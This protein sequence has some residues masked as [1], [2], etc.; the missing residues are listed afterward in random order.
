MG[1]LTDNARAL[2]LRSPRGALRAALSLYSDAGPPR[3]IQHYPERSV[4]VLA[5][6]MDDEVL[7]CGGV[8]ALHHRHGARVQVAYMTDGSRGAA[9]LAA[10]PA[11]QRA[12]RRAA[13][14]ATRR[15]E[16][17]ASGR[18]LG[19]GHQEFFDADDG[20]LSVTPALTARLAELLCGFLEQ[21]GPHLLYLPFISDGHPDHHQTAR[22]CAAALQRLEGLKVAG[23]TLRAYEVWTPLVANRVADISAVQALKQQ[24]LAC[25]R[26]QLADIDYARCVVGLNAYRALTLRGVGYAEAFRESGVANFRALLAQHGQH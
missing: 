14:R 16:A 21:P 23:L 11:P 2:L 22:L 13:L 5:P 10:L 1:A 8:L 4:L 9:G 3:P 12:L 6:H 15:Q 19:V 25:H 17:C 20:A 18:L 24:A 26:S 7:G